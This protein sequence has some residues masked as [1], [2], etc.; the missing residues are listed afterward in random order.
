MPTLAPKVLNRN[1]IDAGLSPPPA[2]AS[3]AEPAS[4]FHLAGVLAFEDPVRDG[5]EA[6]VAACQVAG[7]HI[8]IVTG[9]HPVTAHAI[10]REIGL[11]SATSDVLSGED[12]QAVVDGGD[13]AT[14]RRVHVIARAA[15][16]SP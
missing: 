8:I 15:R 3:G 6:A 13:T 2:C 11:S 16:S 7:I 12:M 14:L 4:G 10:A 9:D 5:V 1:A